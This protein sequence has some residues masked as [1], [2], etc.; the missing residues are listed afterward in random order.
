MKENPCRARVAS[1]VFGKKPA[2]AKKVPVAKKASKEVKPAKKK[3][4][5]VEIEEVRKLD[6]ST[7]VSLVTPAPLEEDLADNFS[8][9]T[10]DLTDELGDEFGDDDEL[11]GLPDDL[12]DDLTEDLSEE[13]GTEKYFRDADAGL[14][15]DD[16]IPRGW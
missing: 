8:A 12:E 14:D 1:K 15:D 4:S 6:V 2:M 3:V 9:D 7:P 13:L 5:Q 11:S 16:S 10:D